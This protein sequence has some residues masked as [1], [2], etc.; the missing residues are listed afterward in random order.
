ME[1]YLPIK[2]NEVLG[3]AGNTQSKRSHMQKTI[4]VQFNLYKISS[5]DT[6]IE[7]KSAIMVMRGWEGKG[8]LI[9]KGF[10]SEV[11]RVVWI[12]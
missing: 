1:F 5:I 3:H 11:K 6:S 10:L 2:G 9:D 7:T 4:V 12:R 8:L